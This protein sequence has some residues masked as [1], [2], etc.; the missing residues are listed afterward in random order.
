MLCSAV[1]VVET[2]GAIKIDFGGA[3]FASSSC[4]GYGCIVRQSVGSFKACGFGCFVCSS[5]AGAKA[6]PGWTTFLCAGD[7]Y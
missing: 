2:D 5:S 3:W 7:A 1:E 4:G 6:E